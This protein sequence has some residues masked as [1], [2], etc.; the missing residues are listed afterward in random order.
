MRAI[1]VRCLFEG[2]RADGQVRRVAVKLA[3]LGVVELP[4]L[5]CTYC[6]CEVARVGGWRSD[7][8]PGEQEDDM[9]KITVHG[10]ATNA[11]LDQPVALVQVDEPLTED[12]ADQLRADVLVGDG[13]GEALPPLDEEGGERS[14]P[15]GSSSTSPAK[16]SSTGKKNATAPR[17]PARTTANR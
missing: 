9:P 6:G 8:A 12:Q 17:K 11:A 14:S 16:P 1:E 7:D 4:R 10:G 2:C 13:T 15:G 3:A 5:V